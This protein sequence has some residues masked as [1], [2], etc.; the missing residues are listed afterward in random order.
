M[1]AASLEG[2]GVG[3]ADAGG[4][5]DMSFMQIGHCARLCAFITAFS[6]GTFPC[7]PTQ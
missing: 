4:S 5:D 6:A 7:P 1:A 3:A 2:V